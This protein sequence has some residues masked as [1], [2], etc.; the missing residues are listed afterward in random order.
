MIISCENNLHKSK[1][2][3]LVKPDAHA[4][5]SSMSILV[6]LFASFMTFVFR[7]VP[8]FYRSV[9]DVSPNSSWKSCRTWRVGNIIWYICRLWWQQ[10]VCMCVCIKSRSSLWH[11]QYNEHFSHSHHFDSNMNSP[12]PLCRGILGRLYALCWNSQDHESVS[13]CT[14]VF[15]SF[16]WVHCLCCASVAIWPPY[17]SLHPT[18]EL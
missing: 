10:C 7:N 3:D 1:P 5:F 2:T 4:W 15:I 12:I 9:A 11:C 6:R 17:T 16:S 18:D 13:V 8:Q 14:G